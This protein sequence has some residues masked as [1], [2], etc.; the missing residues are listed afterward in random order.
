MSA[1]KGPQSGSLSAGDTAGHPD[2]ND[3][4]DKI[5][6]ETIK[7]AREEALFRSGSHVSGPDA[8]EP[9]PRDP[10][11]QYREAGDEVYERLSRRRKILVVA[12]LSFCALQSPISSTSVLAATPEVAKE[13]GTTGS[14]INISNAA[15]MVFMGLSPIVWGPM[16]Q[17]FGRRLVTLVTAVA[18]LALSIGTALA[19][20]LA[21]FFVFRA[22]TAFEGTAFILI[23]A[24]SIGDIYRPTERGTAMGWFMSGT[25]IGPAFGPFLG[26]IIVT[27]S[28]WRS[29]FWLQTALA[30]TGLIGVFFLVPETIHHKK[31]DVLANHG[32]KDRIH[33]IFRMI[34]PLRVL[35]WYRYL[36]LLLVAGASSA[37]VWNMYSLLTPIR[38][39][40]NPRFD[41]ET[42][43]LSGLFYLAPGCGYLLGTFGGGRWADW[44]VKRW[45]R[46]RGSRVPEDRLRSALP[47]VGIV[48]PGCVLVYGWSVDQAK[49]GI[50]LPVIALFL[51]GV[52][53]LF[54]F[55][56]LNTYC[57]DVVPGQ[58]ADV[59]AANFFLRYLAGCLASAVVLPIIQAV[60]VGW[61]STISAGL[62][63]VS[64]GG[65]MLAI[66]RGDSWTRTLEVG[67][68]AVSK[69]PPRAQEQH[70]SVDVER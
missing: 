49:G 23:G 57:L 32:R 17:V 6:L 10:R 48:I 70:P 26:G 19:P 35:R 31:I 61:F 52:A 13:Y 1:S 64:A 44:T 38:Y 15:Y 39:V 63:V 20:N 43:L 30:G 36:N 28:S 65:M 51:Q 68:H 67:Q 11:D 16:S 9:P 3:D 60:G 2:S 45:I 50:P 12:V 34:N 8:L 59:A 46:K 14:I 5:Q 22:I 62:M 54:A 66:R 7:P 27:Y 55:P 29:I 42:P 25:L 18:F 53:Q 40:L 4:T 24:A 37:L 69:K 58:G 47:F 33:A 21:V 56:S 41:L